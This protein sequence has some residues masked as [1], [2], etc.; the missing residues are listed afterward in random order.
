[1]NLPGS[2]TGAES[3]ETLLDWAANTGYSRVWLPDRVVDLREDAA[4]AGTA[5]VRCPT[6]SLE[7]RDSAPE[8]WQ[9]VREDGWFP[10]FC[11]ACGG[12]PPPGGGGAPPRGGGGPAPPPGPHPP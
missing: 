10:G 8:F 6:C 2:A 5:R 11:I 9:S 4:V 3:T 12:A 1:M 7:W